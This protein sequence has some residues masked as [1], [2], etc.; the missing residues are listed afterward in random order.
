MTD[1]PSDQTKIEIPDGFQRTN[2]SS[3]FGNRVGPV[4]YRHFEDGGYVRA[5]PVDEHH[6]NGMGICHG[7]MLMAFADMAFGH[8]ITRATNRYWMT[9]RLVTDFMTT[10]KKG[11]W[12]EGSADIVGTD[13]D[14]YTVKGRIWVGEETI[15]SG[16]GLFKALGE[17]PKQR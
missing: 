8:A 7:G 1:D 6:I 16:T 3:P 10:A 14:F 13:G 4:F 5:F 11:D 17:R 9:I 15:M 2:W 12:V